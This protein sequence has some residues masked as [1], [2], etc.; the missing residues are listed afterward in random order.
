MFKYL[1]TPNFVAAANI[2]SEDPAEQAILDILILL[3]K[4]HRPVD[5]TTIC[6]WVKK[7]YDITVDE[8]DVCI[9]LSLYVTVGVL[10]VL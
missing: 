6:K 3:G 8:L 4:F 5:D 7:K 1:P 2:G 10:R 9:Y